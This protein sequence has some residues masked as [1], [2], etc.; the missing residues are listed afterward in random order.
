MSFLW[1]KASFLGW[2]TTLQCNNT[3]LHSS[4]SAQFIS[5]TNN[6]LFR[7]LYLW[8]NQ[9]ECIV[10]HETTRPQDWFVSIR[11]IIVAEEMKSGIFKEENW[12]PLSSGSHL[13]NAYSSL[14]FHL[15]TYLVE[16]PFKVP[17]AMFCFVLCTLPRNVDI[18]KE[19]N[20]CTIQASTMLY[21]L[22]YTFEM[23]T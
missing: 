7:A 3:A 10:Y 12:K 18:C 9:L 14:F 23:S 2:D 6:N 21:A 17:S 4:M 22:M 8:S 13:L 1:Y 19:A 16:F 5:S 11:Q 15:S 20:G